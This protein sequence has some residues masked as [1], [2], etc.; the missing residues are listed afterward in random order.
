[1]KPVRVLALSP[2]PEAGAGARFRVY[3]YLPA[4]RAAG[5]DVTVAP[6]FT[7]PFFEMVY[8]PGRHVRKAGWFAAQALQRLKL[9]SRRSRYDLFWVYREAVPIGPP[10][11]ERRLARVP[12]RALVYDFDDAIFLPT[13]SDANR[14]IQALKYPQKVSQLIRSSTHVVAGNESLAEYARRYNVS[15]SVIPTC[16]DPARFRPLDPPA[17]QKRPAGRLRI[18]WIGSHSTAK[19][20]RSLLPT[21]AQLSRSHPFELYVIGSPAVMAA[22]GLRMTQAPWRLER[23]IEDFQSCDIGIYPLWNDA[24]AR[25]KCGFKAIQFMACGVPVVADAVGVTQD[26]IQDGLNGFLAMTPQDWTRR[27]TQLL[28]DP[29]LRR[30]LGTAGRETVERRYALAAH[31]PRL[32]EVFRSA[33]AR[34]SGATSWQAHTRAPGTA[35]AVLVPGS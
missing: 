13:T 34:A 25:G 10:W 27:L 21:L 28:L 2:I 6:F 18:G 22:E 19:Y 29:A 35:P 16:V 24:W 14:L 1:M 30:R 33:M 9:L 32:I 26:I 12:G 15:V 4:L 8:Q 7:P 23:E 17:G 31:A 20:L 3:Q 5:F 11:V